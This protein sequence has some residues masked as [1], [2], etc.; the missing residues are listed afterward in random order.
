MT[1][2]LIWIIIGIII[3][4][5]LGWYYLRQGGQV[6]PP[7]NTAE[8]AIESELSGL[9]LGEV[10]KEFSDIDVDLQNL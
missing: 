10:D 8:Q 4:A 3:I 7:A 6:S 9:D 2:N 1:K 5:L